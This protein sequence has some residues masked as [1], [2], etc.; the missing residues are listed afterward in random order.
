MPF[1]RRKGKEKVAGKER[2]SLLGK[3]TGNPYRAKGR[4]K[5]RARASR[6]E[7]AKDIVKEKEK[8]R[9][10]ADAAVSPR[11]ISG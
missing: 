9:V 1:L 11:I 4:A 7:K 10:N 5:G 2:A 3:V 8:A 6:K